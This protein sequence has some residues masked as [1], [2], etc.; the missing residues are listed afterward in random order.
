MAMTDG[1]V[2]KNQQRNLAGFGTLGFGW[3]PARWIDFKAQISGHTAFFKGSD[4][5]ELGNPALQLIVGGTIHF[6]GKT[7]LDIGMSEDIAR[8]TSPDVGMHLALRKRF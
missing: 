8:H 2:L 4:L 3:G 7:S 5:P 1:N 6:P